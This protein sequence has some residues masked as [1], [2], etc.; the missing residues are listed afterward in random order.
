[1]GARQLFDPLEK[2]VRYIQFLVALCTSSGK[3]VSNIQEAMYQLLSNSSNGYQDFVIIPFRPFESGLISV[4]L[5]A[6]PRI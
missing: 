2:P 3:S 6:F 5:P 4:C 1:M